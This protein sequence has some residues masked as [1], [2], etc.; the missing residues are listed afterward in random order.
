MF[1]QTNA[2]TMAVQKEGIA[3]GG[4]KRFVLFKHKGAGKVPPM[5]KAPRA[6]GAE[7]DADDGL[8]YSKIM[9]KR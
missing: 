1:G 4:K 3:G 9:G 8:T 2:D 7:P 5:G 6:F